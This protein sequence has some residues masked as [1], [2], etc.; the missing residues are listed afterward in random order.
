MNKQTYETM[1]NV[2]T[3]WVEGDFNNRQPHTWGDCVAAF[4][5]LGYSREQAWAYCRVNEQGKW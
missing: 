4:L 5:H 1:A 2:L 3:A